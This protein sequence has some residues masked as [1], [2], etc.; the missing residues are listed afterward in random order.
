MD[1]LMNLSS[2][3]YVSLISYLRI[4]KTGNDVIKIL[5]PF[6]HSSLCLSTSGKTQPQALL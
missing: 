2:S 5:A 1:F 6:G 4:R 3:Y